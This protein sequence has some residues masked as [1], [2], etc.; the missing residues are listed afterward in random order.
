MDNNHISVEQQRYATLLGWGARSGL[1]LLIVCFLAYMFGWLP[2]HVPVD[3]LPN[4]W[5][6]PVEDYLK[7]THLTPGWGWL[8]M[9]GEGDFASLVG[10]AWLSSCSLICLLAIIPIYARRRDTVFVMICVIALAVQLLAASGILGV[11]HH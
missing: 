5:V 9:I 8:K 7:Q 1:V 10:I 2:A 3:Q 6:L 11:E 4:L